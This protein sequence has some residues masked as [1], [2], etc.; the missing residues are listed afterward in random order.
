MR[1]DPTYP[2]RFKAAEA[3]VARMLEDEAVRRA[4]DGIRKA[5]Y[6]KGKVVGHEIEYSDGVLLALL[7]ANNP[8]KYR[9][10]FEQKIVGADGG[11]VTVQIEYVDDPPK[12]PTST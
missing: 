9:E 12:T 8:E 5:V 11:P 2:A 3:E 6:Y 10:R 4:H 7:K 1:E